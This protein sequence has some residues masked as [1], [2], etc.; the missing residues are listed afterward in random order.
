MKH[1]LRLILSLGA[2]VVLAAFLFTSLR[3]PAVWETY[4][5]AFLPKGWRHRLILDLL[6]AL[7]V[8]AATYLIV[9]WELMRPILHM[10]E[11]IKELRTGGAEGKP[12]PASRNLGPLAT[13]VTHM[14]KSLNEAVAA[15][16]EE[17]R[18]RQAGESLWTAERLK[19]W[20]RQRLAGRTLVVVSNREPYQ[21]TKEFGNIK[22]STPP[23]GVV[24]ALEPILRACGGTWVAQATGSADRDV[25]DE[26]NRVAVPP[27]HPSYTLRRVWINEEDEKGFYYGFSNE[28][29]WPLCHIAYTRPIFRQEDWQAYQKVNAQFA[30]AVLAEIENVSEPYVL[31]QDYHFALLPQLIKEKRPD[32][33]VALFWHIPWPNPEAFGI[34]PWRKDVLLGMLSA[35]LLGFHTQYHCNHFL[36][37]VD[38]V[39]ESRIDRERFAVNRQ[40]HT[41]RVKAFPISVAF[42]TTVRSAIGSSP[43]TPTKEELF[44]N[45]GVRARYM[46]VGV[47]RL[48]YTK[49]IL[50]RF[51]AIER[52]L[53]V[54]TAYRGEFTFVE[55]GAPSRSLIQR[56]DDFTQEI[57]REVF[58]INQKFETRDWKP[59]VFLKG[60]HSH[61]TIEPY[62]RAADVCMVTSLHDGMNLVAKEFVATRDDENG[63]LILSRF[64][65]ASRELRD[66]LIV[67]P[68]DIDQMASA[69]RL[70]LEMPMEEKQARMLHLRETVLDYNVYRW[71]ANIINELSQIR[72]YAP[73]VL[74]RA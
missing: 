12:P 19:E 67:N 73:P 34:C 40:N 45:L 66:A 52:L 24:T 4:P 54:E 57:E 22:W 69:L 51:R 31:V 53:E 60:Q 18:L 3:M 27:D 2:L 9:R 43:R 15:A 6:Q 17:A 21:H 46:G 72:E 25:V 36:E 68:Y 37:T 26:N 50:E 39:L 20:A 1:S 11:W 65:G 7:T 16:Q 10:S 8:S 30:E 71:G 32:A 56:Y 44:K 13:E 29:L 23:S 48:D 5:L 74:V 61:E 42:P 55:L 33:R 63:V 35:D 70:A 59:I 64:T 14:A 28:G 58:R 47:D 49:G 41:T 38:Q 62:Y